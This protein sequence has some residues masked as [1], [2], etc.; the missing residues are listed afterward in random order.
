M[1]SSTLHSLRV[2]A[3]HSFDSAHWFDAESAAGVRFAIARLTFGRRLDLARRI[4][5]IGRRAE[6]L[7]AGAEARDK[8]AVAVV[9]AEVDRAYLEWG[10]LAVEGLTIDG[11]A[12]TPLAVVEKGPLELATEI[13]GR[14]KAECGLSEIERKN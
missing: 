7:A 2:E 9:G 5:E 8:L 6:F 11:E 1:M 4:R 10:L 13:L 14:V 3:E 12:A